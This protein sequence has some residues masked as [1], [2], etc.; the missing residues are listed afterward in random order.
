M[1]SE[2]DRVTTLKEIVRQRVDLRWEAFAA[3]HPQLAAAVKRS[4]LV[5]STVERLADDPEIRAA[6]EQAAIDE[7][8]LRAIGR[9]VRA[10]DSF[11]DGA[12]RF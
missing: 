9:V 8:T 1:S 10:A 11:L 4:V 2:R 7:A 5:D 12:L 6:L 3:A